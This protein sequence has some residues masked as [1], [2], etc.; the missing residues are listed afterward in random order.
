M[1]KF[2][3]IYCKMI[4]TVTKHR[5]TISQETRETAIEE[6][7]INNYFWQNRIAWTKFEGRLIDG[8][9]HNAL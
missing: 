4:K 3:T 2:Y 7:Q 9:T 1:F 6:L 5:S 8:D